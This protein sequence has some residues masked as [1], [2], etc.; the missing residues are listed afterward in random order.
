MG[1][2]AGRHA[3]E[4]NGVAYSLSG[5]PHPGI[6]RK[7]RLRPDF[8]GFIFHCTADAA[9]ADAQGDRVGRRVFLE[10][11]P[12]LHRQQHQVQANT[13]AQRERI[14]MKGLARRSRQVL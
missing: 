12:G 9:L 10:P 5:V 3:D 6:A 1:L 14:E 13:F 8:D 4:T 11:V 7:H 2:L